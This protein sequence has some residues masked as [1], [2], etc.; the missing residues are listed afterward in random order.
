LHWLSGRNLP[1]RNLNLPPAGRSHYRLFGDQVDLVF[2]V[3][4][5]RLREQPLGLHRP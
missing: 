5:Q 3:V 2:G 4:F 1:A